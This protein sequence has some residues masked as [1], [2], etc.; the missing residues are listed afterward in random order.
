MLFWQ[1]LLTSISLAL[2]LSFAVGFRHL[3]VIVVACLVFGVL[4]DADHGSWDLRR[5]AYCALSK[6]SREELAE[7]IRCNGLHRGVFH[8]RGFLVFW[9]SAT[10]ALVLHHYTDGLL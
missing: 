6:T 1:H 10:V 4:I 8:S 3:P 7:D 5:S 2:V 9:F